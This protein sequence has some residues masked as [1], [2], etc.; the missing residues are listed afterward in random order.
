MKHQATIDHPS[1]KA[2]REKHRELLADIDFVAE[3]ANAARKGD[4]QAA[5]GIVEAVETMLVLVH[6]EWRKSRGGTQNNLFFTSLA[7]RLRRIAAYYR[8]RRDEPTKP[9]KAT[10]WVYEIIDYSQ[11]PFHRLQPWFRAS[12][13]D[14]AIKTGI[15]LGLRELPGVRIWQENPDE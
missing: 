2:L 13:I 11:I 6:V 5:A 9:D 7:T 10:N 12:A 15:L 4:R 8:K 3:R 14:E 1:Q